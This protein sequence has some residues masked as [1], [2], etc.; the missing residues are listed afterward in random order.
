MLLVRR[1]GQDLPDLGYPVGN[2]NTFY[3]NVKL[4]SERAAHFNT[5][6]VNQLTSCK[7]GNSKTRKAFEAYDHEIETDCFSRARSHLRCDPISNP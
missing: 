2:K 3:E 1:G 4:S 5:I 7:K 6:C